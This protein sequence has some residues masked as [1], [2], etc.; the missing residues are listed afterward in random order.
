[1][2]SLLLKRGN[3][4]PWLLLRAQGPVP[5][6][7]K[8][9][10]AMERRIPARRVPEKELMNLGRLIRTRGKNEIPG[11]KPPRPSWLPVARSMLPQRQ[12]VPLGNRLKKQP[13]RASPGLKQNPRKLLK[14]KR[15]K[16]TLKKRRGSPLRPRKPGER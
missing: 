14:H 15:E 16:H 8:R 11:M 4:S 6:R 7:G 13:A 2:T 5:M 10:P 9:A 1:G 12:A 3:M